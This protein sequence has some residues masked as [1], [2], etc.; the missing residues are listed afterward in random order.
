MMGDNNQRDWEKSI[1]DEQRRRLLKGLAIG[2]PM[3]SIAGCLGDGSDGTGNG[4]GNGDTDGEAVVDAALV[5][6]VNIRTLEPPNAALDS[7]MLVIY[8]MFDGLVTFDRDLNVQP[9]L[10]T[11][12]EVVDDTSIEFQLKEGVQF[13]NG[14]E[15]TGDDVKYSLEWFGDPEVQKYGFWENLDSVDV[16]DDYTVTINTTE[17]FSPLLTFLT[18]NTRSGGQIMPAG[19][20]EE[21]FGQNPIGSGPFKFE[22]WEEG[23]HIH[24]SKF[25]DY[26][27]DG[28]PTVDRVQVPLIPEQSTALSAIQAGDVNAIDRVPTESL[29]ELESNQDVDL[30]VTEGALAYR[31]MMFNNTSEPFDD[32]NVRLAFAKAFSSE[33]IVSSVMDGE[34]IVAKGPIPPSHSMYSDD[35]PNHQEYDPE[36]AV[37][38]IEDSS[39]SLSEI[40]DMGIETLTWG[41]GFWFQFGQVASRQ[42]NDTFD[43]NISV[44]STTYESAFSQVQELSYDM[45]TW[46]W[47]GLAAADAYIYQY[48]SEGG[49]NQYRGYSNPDVDELAEQA[50]AEFDPDEQREIYREAQDIIARKAADAFIFYPNEYVATSGV[51]GYKMSPQINYILNFSEVTLE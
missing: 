29:G 45:V 36:A 49:R 35:L 9:E 17:P 50:R 14:E 7:T 51:Q 13:H 27:N 18:G 46:G 32:A 20:G 47:R 44:N 6:S 19:S 8:G 1:E 23:S 12:W 22:E 25:E 3:A 11:D 16:V 38:L 42:M 34:A 33:D 28:I 15:M 31:M 5:G 48:H 40:Q 4:N 21:E 39:Y 37:Q 30:H 24:L 10:A 2:A 41:S 43:M 26:H